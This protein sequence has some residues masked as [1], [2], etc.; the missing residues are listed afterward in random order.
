MNWKPM[1]SVDWIVVH[2]AATPKDRDIGVVEIR[3]WH[4]KQGWAD[5]GYHYVIRRNGVI[6]KGRPENRPGAHVRGINHQS[7]GICLVG[8]SGSNPNIAENN[9]TRHQ[10]NSLR[11]LVAELESRYPNAPVI[12]HRDVPGV[13]KACPSFDVMEWYEETFKRKQSGKRPG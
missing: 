12:G 13:A 11:D 8:G 10:F 3:D 2:C 9:F 4:L 1:L 7:L 5:I 6:E